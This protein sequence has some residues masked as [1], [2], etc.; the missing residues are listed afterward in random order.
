[1][2]P[3][4]TPTLTEYSC[5]DFPFRTTQSCL[6]RYWVKRYQN[7]GLVPSGVSLALWGE[8]ACLAYVT[9]PS[10]EGVTMKIASG[11]NHPI[12]STG[13]VKTASDFIITSIEIG[14]IDWMKAV[15]AVIHCLSFFGVLGSDLSPW[16]Y[17]KA[18]AHCFQL[19]IQKKIFRIVAIFKKHQIPEAT[20][21]I[22]SNKNLLS[23]IK[24]F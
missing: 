11:V 3:W 19:D 14:L 4:E 9:N 15:R 21:I 16:G 17:M 13:L 20:F 1:M 23:E 6:L 12:F 5:E 10:S 22:Y 7:T 8:G 18:S 24:P 2:E